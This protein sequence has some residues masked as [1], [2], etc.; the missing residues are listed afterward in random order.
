[1]ARKKPAIT[2][3]Y[4]APR[5]TIEACPTCDAGIITQ[6]YSHDKGWKVLPEPVTAVLGL[7]H[8]HDKGMEIDF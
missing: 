2:V 5:Q 1:M 7:P 4:E 3:P 6:T 8:K